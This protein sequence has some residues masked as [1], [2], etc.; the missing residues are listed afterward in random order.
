MEN[1]SGFQ[2]GD[3]VCPMNQPGHKMT[4]VGVQHIPEDVLAGG[5]YCLS[6][7][8]CG[9][10]LEQVYTTRQLWLM[11]A[12]DSRDIRFAIADRVKLMHQ[13]VDQK[14]VLSILQ[15]REQTHAEC[16]WQDCFNRVH[17][18]L[19]PLMAIRPV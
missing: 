17:Q 1:I 18:R 2:I 4:V 19:L 13:E 14:P 11:T 6:F 15:I 10:P 7:D 5:Y 9:C 16:R 3:I 12:Y 8:A